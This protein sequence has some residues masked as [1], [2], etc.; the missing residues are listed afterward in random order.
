V[1]NGDC[2]TFRGVKC[3]GYDCDQA[4]PSTAKLMN[5]WNYISA[6]QMYRHGVDG[7]K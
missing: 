5:E 6:S 1:L 7:N 2:G 3:V 4:A